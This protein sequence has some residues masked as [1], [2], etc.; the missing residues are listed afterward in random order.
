[1]KDFALWHAAL[2][3]HKNVTFH[4]YAEVES[5]FCMAGEGKPGPA[6]YEKA[7]HVSGEVVEDIAGW[8]RGR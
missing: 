2:D 8:I 1:M 3:G 4:S 7:G 6:E 5:P